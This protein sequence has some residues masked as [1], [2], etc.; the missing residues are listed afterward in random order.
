MAR[1]AFRALILV[2]L[3][4][5][6]V[7]G[8]VALTHQPPEPVYGNLAP[9]VSTELPRT[10]RIRYVCSHT[11]HEGLVYVMRDG[12]EMDP[13]PT[14]RRCDYDAYRRGYAPEW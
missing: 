9:L 6:I 11:G 13:I 12:T 2:C 10:G 5:C 1:Y 7:I 3:A 8:A 4:A 14:N